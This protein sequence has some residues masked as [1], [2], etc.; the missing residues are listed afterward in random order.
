MKVLK[1]HERNFYK[2]LS[3]ILRMMQNLEAIDRQTVKFYNIHVKENTHGK[4]KT[5]KIWTQGSN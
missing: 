5:P 2:N 4:V 1:N 3:I